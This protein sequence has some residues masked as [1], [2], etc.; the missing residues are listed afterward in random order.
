MHIPWKRKVR[1]LKPVVS[2]EPS[3]PAQVEPKKWTEQL[4][5]TNPEP[6]PLLNAQAYTCRH[7][8]KSLEDLPGQGWTCDSC[9]RR[10]VLDGK[11]FAI[12]EFEVRKN[13]TYI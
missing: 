8:N 1:E 4:P 12:A 6:K 2:T 10:F 3:L 5:P 13:I 9:Q 7:C 11:G